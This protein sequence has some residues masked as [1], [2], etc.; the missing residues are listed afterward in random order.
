[1]MVRDRAAVVAQ[2]IV[3]LVSTLRGDVLRWRIEDLLRGEFW[4]ER[5]QGVADRGRHDDL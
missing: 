1:M 5:R 3:D 4:D 2:Q